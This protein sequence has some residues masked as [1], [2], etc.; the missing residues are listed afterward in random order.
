MAATAVCMAAAAAVQM[1]TTVVQMASAAVALMLLGWGLHWPASPLTT[2]AHPWHQLQMGGIIS[3]S[4]LLQ[5]ARPACQPAVATRGRRRDCAAAAAVGR[6]PPARAQARGVMSTSLRTRA[7]SPPTVLGLDS[8]IL[9]PLRGSGHPHPHPCPHPLQAVNKPHPQPLVELRRRSSR[10][11]AVA[12]AAAAVAATA[13]AAAAAAVAAAVP[14]AAAAV[15]TVTSSVTVS[16]R[17]S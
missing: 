7:P 16:L 1:A 8:L 4:S 9:T 14:A 17:P 2:R 11:A 3:S 10:A 5:P 6:T 15:T 12:A 13:V